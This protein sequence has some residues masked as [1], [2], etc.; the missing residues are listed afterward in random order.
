MFMIVLFHSLTVHIS[1]AISSVIVST[2]S[3][4]VISN[5]AIACK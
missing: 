2:S 4:I 5:V 3:A 1:I